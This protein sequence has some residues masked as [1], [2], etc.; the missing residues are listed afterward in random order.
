MAAGAPL[1]PE[2]EADVARMRALSQLECNK[3]D[4][5][6]GSPA[7]PPPEQRRRPQVFF[8]GQETLPTEGGGK[9]FTVYRVEVSW[10]GQ[11]WTLAKR[12]S[13]FDELRQSIEKKYVVGQTANKQEWPQFPEK[14][15]LG[16]F[17]PNLIQS[18]SFALEAFVL[19]LL[20]LP[21]VC[22]DRELLDFL[23]TPIQPSSREIEAGRRRFFARVRAWHQSARAPV[24]AA[25]CTDDDVLARW[26]WEHGLENVAEVDDIWIRFQQANARLNQRTTV[27]AIKLQAAMRGGRLRRQLHQRH[28]AAVQIQQA[29]RTRKL[30]S[31]EMLKLEGGYA[32]DCGLRWYLQGLSAFSPGRASLAAAPMFRCTSARFLRLGRHWQL[33]LQIDRSAGTVGVFLRE[34]LIPPDRGADDTPSVSFT[35]QLVAIAAGGL[36][37]LAHHHIRDCDFMP[38]PA[39]R[40]PSAATVA[41][42]AAAARSSSSAWGQLNLASLSR[43]RTAALWS[44]VY[45]R[46]SFGAVAQTNHQGALLPG[47][48]SNTGLLPWTPPSFSG[49]R[50]HVNAPDSA[51]YTPPSLLARQHRDDQPIRR[52][53]VLPATPTTPTALTSAEPEAAAAVAV[54]EADIAPIAAAEP[55]AES[56]QT[57]TK[58][59]PTTEV[60][61]QLSAKRTDDYYLHLS[62]EWFL[63][64]GSYAYRAV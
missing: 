29:V 47:G 8:K 52:Q 45:V 11:S 56:L 51:Q 25:K 22:D 10:L 63:N 16:N 43:I 13:E 37:N 35:L 21:G 49:S 57:A 28:V 24:S 27:A 48:S 14:R 59:V 36:T 5:L 6:I 60:R 4:G 42:A 39:E 38:A 1:L 32:P 17:D 15:I 31:A 26:G 20:Q 7:R 33:H 30:A 64:H 55:T 50:L 61:L 40:Q 62:H 19:A 44:D 54:G 3:R 2:H 23:Q 41:A 9:K 34:V 53:L 46:L 18:R 58:Q 12:Y